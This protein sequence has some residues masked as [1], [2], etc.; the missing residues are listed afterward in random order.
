MSQSHSSQRGTGKMSKN[1]GRPNKLWWCPLYIERQLDSLE[2]CLDYVKLNISCGNINVVCRRTG[3]TCV[4]T[5]G[6]I[7]WGDKK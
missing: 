6:K 3:K 7:I 1:T 4:A 2:D 5:E